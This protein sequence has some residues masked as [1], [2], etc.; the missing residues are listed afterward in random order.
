MRQAKNPLRGSVTQNNMVR[1]RAREQTGI[2]VMARLGILTGGLL[3]FALL[4]FW[5]WSKGWPQEKAHEAQEAFIGLTQKLQ[6]AVKDITV[7]GRHQSSKDSVFDAL[8]T[9]QGAPI[10][11]FDAKVAAARLD[12]LPWVSSA[13]VERRLPDTIAVI[14]NE[15]V[16]A[17]RWQHDEKIVVV[18]SD[19]H[20]LP[21]ARAEDFPDLP[22]IV[23]SGAPADA[24]NLFAALKPYPDIAAKLE[25]AVR[26]SER[27]WDLHLSP[28]ITVKL[29]E[30]GLEDA[31][32]RL[33]VLINQDKILDRDITGIDLRLSDRLIVEP[34]ANAK[35][36]T[37]PAPGGRL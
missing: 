5:S 15:R 4:C 24:Q 12:K 16:P 19:G 22:Q 34:A 37:A 13:I 27:R 7:E 28:R 14:L 20:V 31:L 9:T 29:P 32:H 30:D 25:S 11:D 21:V 17:A 10:F 23:G 36:N 6:F 33:S 26:V 18:D 8:G 3:V 1:L 35:P 2:S